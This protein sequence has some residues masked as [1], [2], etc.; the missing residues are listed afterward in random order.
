MFTGYK[1]LKVNIGPILTLD[2]TSFIYRYFFRNTIE[3]Q[4]NFKENVEQFGGI[5]WNSLKIIFKEYF[6][7]F[8]TNNLE[9]FLRKY[10][11]KNSLKFIFL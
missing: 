11:W 1:A 7:E 10:R 2:T 5:S 6:G 3:V 8:L 9:E 4:G